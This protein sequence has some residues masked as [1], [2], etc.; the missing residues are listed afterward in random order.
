MKE[1]KC[2]S[3]SCICCYFCDR[4]CKHA[5]TVVSGHCPNQEQA[6]IGVGEGSKGMKVKLGDKVLRLG[7]D[8]SFII[9]R[10]VNGINPSTISVCSYS[11]GSGDRLIETSCEPRQHP[12][13]WR[14]YDE[15][16]VKRMQKLTADIKEKQKELRELYHS[17]PEIEL[18]KEAR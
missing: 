5:N 3:R 4:E 12:E 17:L 7:Y 10:V 16:K 6:K 11:K 1:T 13:A 9:V 15:V 8:F 2:I 18:G 14:C